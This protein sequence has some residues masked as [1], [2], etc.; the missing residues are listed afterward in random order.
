MA[1]LLSKLRG[2]EH[3]QGPTPYLDSL[4][5]AFIP[6]KK[7]SQSAKTSK[8]VSLQ[9]LLDPLSERELDMLRL[10]AHGA[11]NQEIAK[12]LVVAVTTV[13]HHVSMILSK[14]G[15]EMMAKFPLTYHTYGSIFSLFCTI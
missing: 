2:Q 12:E 3:K 10:L 4:L 11:S 8:D 5:A 1:A 6:E 9:P 13:K 14:L 7:A 15:A